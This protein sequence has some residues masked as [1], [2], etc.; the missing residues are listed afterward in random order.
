MPRWLPAHRGLVYLSGAFEVLLGIALLVPAT[1]RVA[2]YRSVI[3]AFQ[4]AKTSSF[5]PA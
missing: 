3:D 1:Q 5:L 4:W 2:A